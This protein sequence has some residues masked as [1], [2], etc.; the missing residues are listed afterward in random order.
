MQRNNTCTR[1]PVYG[2]GYAHLSM[3][4]CNKGC[5]RAIAQANTYTIGNIIDMYMHESTHIV[6][7]MDVHVKGKKLCKLYGTIE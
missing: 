6:H 2:C 7:D 4:K 3:S 5:K 1:V